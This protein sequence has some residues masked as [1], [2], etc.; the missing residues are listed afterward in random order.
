MKKPFPLICE[1][2]SLLDATPQ[3][4]RRIWILVAVIFLATIPPL[5]ADETEGDNV[6]VFSSVAPDYVR[7]RLADGS[8][9]PETYAFG[10]GG[11]QGGPQKDITID[12]LRFIDIARI[13]A[14]SLAAQN[15]RSVTTKD[16]QPDLL[17]MVY[18]GTTI[19]TDRTSSSSEYQLAQSFVPPPAPPLPPPPDGTGGTAMVSDPD[20]SGRGTIMAQA[21]AQKIAADSAQQLALTMSS[22]A[23][24]Q[25]DRLNR[26]NAIILGYADEIQRVDGYE[27]TALAGR[28][29][30][31]VAE[32][33]ESRYYVVLL[34]YDFQLLQK[35]KQ[36]KML[37]QTRYSIPERR[38]D[39]SKQLAAMTRTASHYFGQS[40][41][42]LQRKPLPNTRVE[43]GELKTIG[44]ESD[45]RK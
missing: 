44:V 33:E 7:S 42:G 25:R 45:T 28:R 3:S 19:G 40:S 43:L 12:R 16:A 14:P 24:R 30:D 23:N 8:F 34:A 41:A 5:S 17:I 13:I 29:R 27:M 35:H 18:W 6:A 1:S 32:V 2:R 4:G 20:T 36:R 37:W 31:V 9:K 10:E 39:F 21:A 22:M 11:D 26:Q 15:Y 38:N